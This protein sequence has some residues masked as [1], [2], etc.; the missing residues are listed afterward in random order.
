MGNLKEVLRQE[1]E[2]S[3]QIVQNSDNILTVSTEHTFTKNSLLCNILHSHPNDWREFM[4]ENYKCISIKE[5]GDYAIFNYAI[6]ADFSNPVVR[7]ARGIIINT[8]FHQVVCRP[9]YKFFK[10]DEPYHHEINWKCARAEEK[11]DGSLIKLWYDYIKDKWVFS[12]NSTIYAEY[13]PLSQDTNLTFLDAIKSAD[14]YGMIECL[15]E[16]NELHKDCTYMFELI[17][18]G[19]QVV[20]KYDCTRLY[21]IGTRDNNT[22]KE[23]DI[24]LG[25]VRPNRQYVNSLDFCIN[26]VSKVLNTSSK[27]KI[28]GCESEGLVVVDNEFNRIKVKSPIYVILHNLVN[29][30]ET[31]KKLLLKL[32]HED[33]I[34]IDSVCRQFPNLS[35]WIRYYA[36][37][38]DEFAYQ[39]NS[40][41]NITRRLYEESTYN[42][43]LV[44][45][46]IKGHKYSSIAFKALDNSDSV[47]KIMDRMTGGFIYVLCKFIPNYEPENYG[48]LFG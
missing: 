6:G 1:V 38:Y 39:V 24:D 36:F 29:N 26:Y 22:G 23:Y 31:S 28:T 17:G 48:Y 45:E 7:E 40:F 18:R 5:D 21:H 9:F 15:I 13:A 30:G 42:R 33:R 8:V 25:I 14:N 32:I 34:D 10:Y 11:I 46:R 12:T 27:N 16:D 47:E 2:K 4:A 20:I 44:A 19:N 43:K 3:L 37:K 35:H 41:V